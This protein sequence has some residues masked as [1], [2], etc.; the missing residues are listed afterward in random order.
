MTEERRKL[1]REL[2]AK[3]TPGPWH[4][5]DNKL[6]RAANGCYVG[7]SWPGG[8]HSNADAALIAAAPELLAE[9]LD[10]IDR[11]MTVSTGKPHEAVPGTAHCTA[12]D[13]RRE[14]ER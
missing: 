13:M 5:S 6:I 12:C 3:A 7:N 2:L 8:T 10:A 1:A 4:V 14:L 9:A 11:A